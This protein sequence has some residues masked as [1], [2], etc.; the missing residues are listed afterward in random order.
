MPRKPRKEEPGAIHHVFARGVNRE[1]IFLDVLDCRL[2]LALLKA[3]ILH[4]GWLCM[5]Y[6]LMPNHMHLLIETPQP[7]LGLG[8]QTLHG[9]YGLA[10]NRRYGRIGHLFQDRYRSERIED[11]GYFLTVASYIPMNPVRARLC[12]RPE[13]WPW[14]SHKATLKNSHPAWIAAERL[15]DYIEDFCG[16]SYEMLVNAEIPSS[17]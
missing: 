1:A 6:C 8:M 10:F 14:S 3:T 7:N 4:Y 13:S 16:A 9:T 11:E 5:S 17:Y 2:Y 12:R 15:C